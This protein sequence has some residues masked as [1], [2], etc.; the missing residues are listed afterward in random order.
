ML[1]DH[2][3]RI[4][5]A[6]EE[7]STEDHVAVAIGIAGGSEIGSILRVELRHEVRGI[8]QIWIRVATTKIV[9]GIAS[10]HDVLRTKALL[11]NMLGVRASRPVHCVEQHA[12]TTVEMRSQSVEIK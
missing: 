5:R 1:R 9:Q 3:Q 2:R 7:T 11:E 6:H 10:H 4:T 12:E 8:N